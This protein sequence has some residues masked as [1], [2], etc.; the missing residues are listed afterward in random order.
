[1]IRNRSKLIL[2]LGL[3]V[4]PFVAAEVTWACGATDVCTDTTSSFQAI[5][6]LE[7]VTLT[8]S[9]DAEALPVAYYQLRRY[10]CSDPGTCSVNVAT[11]SL[12]GSC[13]EMANYSYTD[14][15]PAPVSAWTYTLEVW[16]TDNSRACATDTRPQ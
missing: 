5:I 12:T 14:H 6:I 11:V 10:D 8:W 16:K 2:L 1:M 13:G 4:V 15:P 9:T 3:L 7:G